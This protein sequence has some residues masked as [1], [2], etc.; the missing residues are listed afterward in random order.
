MKLGSMLRNSF[1]FLLLVLLL[2][3]ST[4]R[5]VQKDSSAS[6]DKGVKNSGVI[7]TTVDKT[8]FVVTERFVAR[9]NSLV[10]KYGKQFNPP[11]K[12]N[13]GVISYKDNYVIDNEHMVKMAKMNTWEKN[14][15]K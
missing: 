11:V 3:C 1:V 13:A 8:G 7:S 15:L 2:G 14:S 10:E 12:K 5:S 9:Y 4:T 6:Y